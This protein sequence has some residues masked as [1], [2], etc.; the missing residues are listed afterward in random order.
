[1][2]L[3]SEEIP[4]Y[5]SLILEEDLPPL[6]LK[7]IIDSASSVPLYDRLD[8]DQGSLCVSYL[9]LLFILKVPKI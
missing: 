9:K 6:N 3:L 1:M 5:E 2:G 4:P 8:I 7:S